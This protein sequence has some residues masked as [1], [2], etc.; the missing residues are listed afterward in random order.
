MVTYSAISRRMFVTAGSVGL[1]S[2]A[3]PSIVRRARAATEL[4]AVSS[5]QTDSVFNL[6][7]KRLVELVEQQSKG[8]VTIR[9]VGGPD[10]IPPLQAA[11]AVRNGVFD[12]ALTTSSYF[13]AAMPE[14]IAFNAG[15]ADMSLDAIHRSGLFTLFD[16]TL[17]R[18]LG[19]ALLGLNMTGVGY[20]FLFA[21]EPRGLAETFQSK[22]VRTASLYEPLVKS[23]GGVSVTTPPT[24]AYASVERGVVDGLAWTTVGIRDYRFHEVAPHMLLPDFYAYRQ[25]LMISP[26]RLDGL[27]GDT[28]EL[29]V[30]AARE[31]DDWGRQEAVRL[32][33]EERAKMTEEGLKVSTLETADAA[34]FLALADQTLWERISAIIPEA[35]SKALRE[36]FEKASSL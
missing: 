12:I 4:T 32:V 24:E 14:A 36:A 33:N 11:E 15:K 7:L 31:A 28:R 25:V 23:L 13:T 30:R 8:E 1:A 17:R 18:K 21:K 26:D 9:F 10:A 6:P 35:E 27:D 3:L 16:E 29:L 2:L 34:K 20:V 5:Y 19:T 22:K